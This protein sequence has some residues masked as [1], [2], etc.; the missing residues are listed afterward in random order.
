MAYAL[1]LQAV[2]LPIIASPIAY[3]LGRR[4]G[5]KASWFVFAVIL[6][7]TL[8]LLISAQTNPVDESYSWFPQ[9]LTGSLV[10]SSIG[11]FGLY[12]DGISVPFAVTIYVIA[13]SVV[14]YSVPYM[15]RKLLEQEEVATTEGTTEPIETPKTN[16][17]FG[18]Y[19]ALYLLYSGGMVGT[20]LAT[21]LI[22]LYFMFE[23]MLVP[24]YF[25]IAE[26]G[27]S[28]RGRV[29]MMYLL[30]THI[31]ALMMLLSFLAIGTQ[32]ENFVFLGPGAVT[33]A[34]I[35][36]GLIPWIAFGI[37][38]G[39]FVKLAAFGLHVWLPSTYDEAPTPITA[40]MSAAMTGIGGYILIRMLT[41]LLPGEYIA[42]GIGLGVWGVVTMFYGGVMAL[43]Q[44]DFKKLLAYSSISQMGYIIFGIATATQLGVAGSVFQ[45]VSHA[46]SKALL[47]MVVGVIMIQTGGLKDIRKMGGLTAKLPI[48]A[49][50]AM[51]G[52]LGLLGF[53]ETSGFQSE[54][55]IFGG[56]L[57]LGSQIGAVGS[58]WL[59]L[60]V[61][62]VVATI[63]TAAYALWSMKRIF[64]GQLPEQL[65]NVKEASPYMLAPIIFLAALTIL[66]GIIPSIVDNPLFATISHLIPLR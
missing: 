63:V 60:S 50:C 54:W 35:A 43:A 19:L 18:L 16:S 44:N 45:F 14:V 2:L 40:L 38:V 64:F 31:G 23:F 34:Q 33:A 15:K 57:Q 13:A 3:F 20:V 29:S 26:F 9:S 32:T 53:P 22:E 27:Y 56:G 62:A 52:F 1:L 37:V 10:L 25:L 5:S 59:A 24:S 51:I 11:H 55:L 17:R 48:T 8:A 12:L 39:M 65:S 4:I 36:A 58:W 30:W 6:Y 21:N 28:S 49:T 42:I 47:F 7:S 66:L 41:L 61:L 46:T